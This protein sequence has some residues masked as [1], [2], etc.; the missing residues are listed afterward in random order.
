VI[1]RPVTLAMRR[2]TWRRTRRGRPP[3]RESGPHNTN[4][5]IYEQPQQLSTVTGAPA[6]AILT[7]ISAGR[8]DSRRSRWN[9]DLCKHLAR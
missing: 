1:F 5:L 7:T 2:R 3:C 6:D 8:V 9:Y 4:V